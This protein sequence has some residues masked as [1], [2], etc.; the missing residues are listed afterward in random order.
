MKC[1]L[2]EKSRIGAGVK[3]DLYKNT[4]DEADAGVFNASG[5]GMSRV[6]I[7]F[8]NRHRESYGFDA[9]DM[10]TVPS[11]GTPVQLLQW[12]TPKVIRTIYAGRKADELFGVVN[13][14]SWE[15]EEVVV[16]EIETLGDVALYND[17]VNGE[18]ANFNANF[19]K[20]AV[21]RFLSTVSVGTL[22][23]AQVARMRI[24]AKEKKMVAATNALEIQR[25]LVA[26]NGFNEGGK[27][28][29]GFLNDP[30]LPAYGTL[31]VGAAGS[32]MLKDKTYIEIVNDIRGMV[33]ELELKLNGNFDASVDAFKL[34]LPMAASQSM[35]AVPQYGANGFAGSVEA[36]FKGAYPKGEIHYVPQL[37][38]A[39]GGQNVIY[40]FAEDVD[41]EK[42]ID[43]FVQ[44]RMFLVGFER[45]DT[46]F[47]ETYSNATAGA[48]VGYGIGVVRKVGA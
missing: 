9:V 16:P 3:A 41:G 36:W 29:Y 34:V 35:T 12:W 14:G 48:F 26:F 10:A 31:S 38:G 2:E 22:E 20:R 45:R 4:Y 44:Q 40:V 27:A 21:V 47:K 46:Y 24:D 6:A 23:A 11:V 19:N 1:N 39:L 17:Y 5:I 25:N 7:D 33:R 32:T 15:D 37:D 43:Q 18:N 8:I 28:N 30:R 13:A 42:N